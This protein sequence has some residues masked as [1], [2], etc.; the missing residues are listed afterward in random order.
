MVLKK[1]E[2][3]HNFL[4]VKVILIMPKSE[5]HPKWYPDAKV[6]YKGEVV[7]PKG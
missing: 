6:I 3:L 7:M 1:Q 5:I 4:N 2:K